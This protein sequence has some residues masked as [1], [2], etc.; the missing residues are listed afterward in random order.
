VL[1]QVRRGVPLDRLMGST[2]DTQK[3]VSSLT[4]FQAVAGRVSAS[5]GVEQRRCLAEAAE[6]ILDAAARQGW[7][8]CAYTSARLHR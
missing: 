5:D 8:R 1:E 6:Q 4:L 3:L 7:P 2:I